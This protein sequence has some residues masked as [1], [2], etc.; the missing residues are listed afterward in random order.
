MKHNTYTKEIQE[1]INKI[2]ELQGTDAKA[3][4]DYCQKLLSYGKAHNDNWILGFA[5]YY[6]GEAYYF[7]NDSKKQLISLYTGIEYLKLS[8]NH[9][10]LARSYNL[11]GILSNAQG[12]S[13]AALDYYLQGLAICLPLENS[14]TIGMI[15]SNIA[16][17]FSEVGHHDKAID[18]L[19]KAI[20]NYKKTPDNLRPIGNLTACYLSMVQNYL[21]LED[22]EAA[23]QCMKTA[24]SYLPQIP[25]E[26]IGITAFV[27]K[28]MLAD[29]MGQKEE[30]DACIQEIVSMSLQECSF[31]TFYDDFLVL[32]HFL[33]KIGKDKAL[34]EVLNPL[35][36]IALKDGNF[37]IQLELIK[38]K[39]DYYQR[40]NQDFLFLHTARQ[41]YDLYLK[42]ENENR[43]NIAASFDL[44]FS[45]VELQKQHKKIE[46]ENQKLIIKSESD[47]LT[48]LPNRYKLNDYSEILLT[49]AVKNQASLAVEILDIDY[50][51]QYN[52]TYGHQAGDECLKAIAQELNAITSDD[53]FCA[54]YGGDEFIILY[55]N[56]T[57]E[58][59][60][61]IAELLRQRICNLQ[62]EH[63]NSL[64]EPFVT[65]TQGI[66]F[67][68]PNSTN[69]MWDFLHIADNA[70]Y[71]GKHN[72]RNTTTFKTF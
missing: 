52:D 14:Y 54:R 39:L 57:Q 19:K 45:L 29:V 15:Y 31:L 7:S 12:N 40:T 66:V 24:E 30:R 17:L 65:I 41:F 16:I 46:E 44:R 56:K 71:E 13:E 42:Q 69:R 11:L 2:L 50:F 67:H 27:S 34:M 32:L 33:Q 64:A 23:L 5:Y 21:H 20:D 1:Y 38:V 72:C 43:K 4:L 37:H 55:Y 49:K 61:Q 62:I 58:E 9:D 60:K 63:K 51:K 10:L 70:L 18:F 8:Q 35:E 3:I 25:A 28:A 22:L 48:G 59:V 68:L 6:T 36:D 53:I 47:A 26:Y